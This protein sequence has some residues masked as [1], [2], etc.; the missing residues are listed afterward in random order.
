MLAAHSHHT[1]RTRAAV[2]AAYRQFSGT[3][4]L[5]EDLVRGFLESKK[6]AAMRNSRGLG[7]VLTYG[8]VLRAALKRSAAPTATV[9]LYLTALNKLG[10]Q[11][12]AR[13][14]LPI[15]RRQLYAIQSLSRTVWPTAYWAWKTASRVG[16]LTCLRR[17]QIH[18]Q[19]SDVAIDWL[20]ATK[21]GKTTPF[22]LSNMTL[23]S[24]V[25]PSELL[26][27]ERLSPDSWVVPHRSTPSFLKA[28]HAL[29]GEYTALS[30]HSFKRG[31][32]DELMRLAAIGKVPVEVIPRLLKHKE[33]VPVLPDVTVRY[34]SD[35]VAIARVGRT[36]ELTA[37]L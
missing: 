12:P 5:Q 17:K 26:R 2:L 10:A 15:T 34:G 6:Q 27:V 33:P 25:V 29:R 19:G 35:R 11:I 9:G 14:A 16:E 22:R 30:A 24:N 3:P 13:Q 8:K 4:S 7:G 28:L 32:A 36:G 37:Q 1:H 20:S 23:V 18:I 31:A 21:S